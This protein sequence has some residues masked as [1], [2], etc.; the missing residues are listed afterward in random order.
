MCQI[1]Y[2]LKMI[3]QVVIRDLWTEM[4]WK[5][6]YGKISNDWYIIHLNL[7]NQIQI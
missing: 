7:A 2:N 4:A 1:V 3:I 5:I 6:I